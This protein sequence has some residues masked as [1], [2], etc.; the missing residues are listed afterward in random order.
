MA[1]D[2]IGSALT[3]ER[4]FKLFFVS[5]AKIGHPLVILGEG[6]VVEH[7]TGEVIPFAEFLQFSDDVFRATPAH[8]PPEED[9]LRR[10]AKVTVVAAA[11]A[12]DEGHKGRW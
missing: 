7:E 1:D 11:S 2:D 5:L 10:L 12:G 4:F 6:V 3:E 8:I 9:P